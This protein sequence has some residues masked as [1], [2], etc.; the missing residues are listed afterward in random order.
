M[1]FEFGKFL[2]TEALDQIVEGKL[3][4]KAQLVVY[5]MLSASGPMTAGELN[6]RLAMPHQSA[7]GYHKRLSE[8]ERCGVVRRGNVR[9]CKV[10]GSK[11]VEWE[12][13]GLLP[14]KPEKRV[15]APAPTPDLAV[16]HVVMTE[17]EKK[18]VEAL[19]RVR[20][21]INWM[22][23]EQKF[24]NGFVFDYLDEAIDSVEGDTNF[25]TT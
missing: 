19:K 22:L 18:L 10:T 21:D 1:E 20:G 16:D 4:P 15:E 8:L 5:T 13:T 11:A 6:A 23:N 7:P 2:K 9:V 3:L 25:P 24:L 17:R 12:V 14:S